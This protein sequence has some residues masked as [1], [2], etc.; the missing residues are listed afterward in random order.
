MRKIAVLGLTLAA[1]LGAG[2]GGYFM[3]L[4]ARPHE[5]HAIP[6]DTESSL[7]PASGQIAYYRDPDG[8]RYSPTPAKTADGRAYLPVPAS[9]ELSFDANGPV[10]PPSAPKSERR[11]AYYRNPM[12]LAD[13]SPVPKKDSMGMDYL[14]VYADEADASTVKIAPGRVQLTGVRS[15]PAERRVISRSLHVPGIVQLDERRVTVVATRTDAFVN[16]VAD[17]TT[18]ERVTKGQPLAK[19]FSTEIA[20][21]GAQFV[22]DLNSAGRD[23][24]AGGA[25]QRL[26]NLGVPRE[27]IDEIERTR[28]PPVGVTWRAPRDGIVVER[29][30]FDGMKMEAGDTLFRI[31]DTSTVWV[32]LDV[33]EREIGSLRPA[34]R[35]V[36]SA[37][38]MP[39]R[40]FE[41]RLGII[42]PEVMSS[43]RTVKVRVQLGNADGAL[44]PNMLVNAAVETGTTNPVIAVPDGAI[45]DSGVRQTVILDRGDGRFE[46]RA[47]RVGMRGDGGSEILQGLAEGDRVVVAGAFLIDAESNLKAALQALDPP[48]SQQ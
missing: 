37:R 7:S 8:P 13:T 10:R 29:K 32:M 34:A 20:A 45:I 33:P 46:P 40:T 44:L 31:A 25:R 22:T 16:E 1:G 5:D 24:L 14:P 15:V 9:E 19:L 48:E 36:I 2:I 35:V 4:S 11:I 3:G 43:T 26:E 47:V 6:S 41:G 42:Q 28:K 38:G 18:G 30:A 12:G 23:G 21:V 39:G 17:V 27:T